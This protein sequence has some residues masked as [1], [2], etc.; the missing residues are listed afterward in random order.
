MGLLPVN[1]SIRRSAQ[2]AC[3]DTFRPSRQDQ[4]IQGRSLGAKGLPE[5]ARYQIAT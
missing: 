2:K 1:D 5:S 4:T 3:Q